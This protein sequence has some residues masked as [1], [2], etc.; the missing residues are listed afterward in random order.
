MSTPV[1]GSPYI[2]ICNARINLALAQDNN[3]RIQAVSA[4]AAALSAFMESHYKQFN[5]ADL[6][7]ITTLQHELMDHVQ[8]KVPLTPEQV[9]AKIKGL[10][11][12]MYTLEKKYI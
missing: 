12:E 11:K 4:G 1:S 7:S 9:D 3:E 2:I 6:V 5:K 8:G 10:I